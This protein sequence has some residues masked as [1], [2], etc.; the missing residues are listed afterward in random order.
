[1][2][3]ASPAVAEYECLG[4]V[5]M[6]IG[7]SPYISMTARRPETGTGL[8]KLYRIARAVE[9]QWVRDIRVDFNN[10]T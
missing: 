8:T 3:S 9:Y 6:V 10:A 2:G 1:M 7:F 5:P 4:K